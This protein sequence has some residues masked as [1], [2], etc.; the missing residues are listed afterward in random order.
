MEYPGILRVTVQFL[1]SRGL[2]PSVT[3]ADARRS[4]NVSI[5]VHRMGP[6]VLGLGEGGGGL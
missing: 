1:L 2:A 4:P 3:P 6:A 5:T